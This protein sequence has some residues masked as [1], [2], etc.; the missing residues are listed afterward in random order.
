MW[1]RGFMARPIRSIPIHVRG[2]PISGAKWSMAASPRRYRAGDYEAERFTTIQRLVQPG[3]VFW[4]VG[5]HFG[6][7]S[8][9]AGRIVGHNGAIVCVEPSPYN[10]WFLQKH[11]AWN[12]ID[13]TVLPYALGD[14]DNIKVRFGGEQTSTTFRIGQGSQTVT[15]RTLP[16][17]IQ[18]Y[19]LRRPTVIKLDVEG[20]ESNALRAAADVLEPTTALMVSV[21][22]LENYKACKELL[23]ARGFTGL[24]SR[25]IAQERAKY[26]NEWA[27]DPD[28]LAFGSARNW[29]RSD[30]SQSFV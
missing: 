14:Q 13:A 28:L 21:H 6:Y 15:V 20:N 5:A 10:R 23:Q 27:H 19:Q 12:G 9:I 8:L 2:G 22:S 18:Q 4:D 30:F 1:L 24:D 26:G 16:S 17:L 25:E 7:A 3:D 11:L 29:Q